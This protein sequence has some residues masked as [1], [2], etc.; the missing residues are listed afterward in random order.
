MDRKEN[1]DT[2]EDPA[3]DEKVEDYLQYRQS[4]LLHFWDADEV[5]VEERSVK[6]LALW[7][8]YV[9]LS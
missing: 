3:G 6:L 7:R 4:R 5:S 8:R 2:N 9:V 1:G